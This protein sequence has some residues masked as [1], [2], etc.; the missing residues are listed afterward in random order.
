LEGAA[1]TRLLL[2]PSVEARD[3]AVAKTLDFVD[4]AI[5]VKQARRTRGT[6]MS[7]EE[8]LEAVRALETGTTVIAAIYLRSGDSHGALTALEKAHQRDP[9]MTRPEL[10][11]ALK[12]VVERPDSDHW[13]DLARLLRPP[14]QKARG[15]ED[16]FGRDTDLLR[17]AAF[18]SACEAYR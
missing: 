3:D 14:P 8:G 6:Q 11:N 7:R 9:Q 4:K 16:D 13:L 17:A 12:A 18:V 1:V 2:E 5:Q 15:D 10:V